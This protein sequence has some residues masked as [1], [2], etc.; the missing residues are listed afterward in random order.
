[1][2]A[3]DIIAIAIFVLF[4]V[5]CA[6][7]GFLKILAKWGAF[8]AATILSKLFGAKVGLLLLGD[9]N[10]LSS[11]SHIIGTVFLFVVLFFVCRIIFGVVAKLITKALGTKAIDKVL[12]AVLGVVGGLAAV[13]LF[14]FVADFIVAIVSVFD[15]DANIVHMINST[16]ILKYF[17]I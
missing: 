10:I 4:V 16:S 7:R 17:M 5:I 6:F 14:A 1:M 15:A 3:F 13:F 12:G 8:F 11:F 9:V 2:N